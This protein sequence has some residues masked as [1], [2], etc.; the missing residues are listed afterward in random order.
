MIKCSEKRLKFNSKIQIFLKSVYMTRLKYIF[1]TI[2]IYRI[3]YEASD[4]T[5]MLSLLYILF[6]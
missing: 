2:L 6:Q 1:T 5:A 4:F 3:R